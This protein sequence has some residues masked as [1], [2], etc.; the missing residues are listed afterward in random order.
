LTVKNISTAEDAVKLDL[1]WVIKEGIA[2]KVD[3]SGMTEGKNR[4]R[5]SINISKEGLTLYDNS[6]SLLWEGG[7]NGI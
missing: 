7:L 5:L 2:D 3:A 1:A 4:F 6:Y